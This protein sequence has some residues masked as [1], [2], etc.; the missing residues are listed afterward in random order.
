MD[1]AANTKL[2]DALIKEIPFLNFHIPYNGGVE[3]KIGRGGMKI[4]S[5]F[6][7]GGIDFG[8]SSS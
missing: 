1:N 8:N 4:C 2:N 6:G 5:G 7:G 3:N